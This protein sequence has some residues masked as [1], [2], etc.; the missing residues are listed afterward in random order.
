MGGI[1]A[2]GKSATLPESD[3][4]EILANLIMS[5]KPLARAAVRFSNESLELLRKFTGP[6]GIA[7]L[8]D[9]L[10]ALHKKTNAIKPRKSPQRSHS[11]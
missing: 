8:R 10:D 6:T 7:D 9:A 4:A 2:E 5:A 3:F 11:T 1:S